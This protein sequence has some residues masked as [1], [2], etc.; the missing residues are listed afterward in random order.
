MTSAVIVSLRIKTTPAR[1]FDV[2]TQ[3][4]DAWWQP[5]GLFDLTPKGDGVLRFEPGE[6][7]RL[8]TT[9]PNGKEFE[10]GR[11]L[12]WAPGERLMFTWRQVTFPPDLLTEVDVRFEPVGKDTRV[13]LEHRG[14]DRV[15]QDH[16]ARHG[17]PL[18]IFQKH[19]ADRHYRLLCS[20]RDHL[21]GRPVLR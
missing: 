7:G 2:F 13:T 19:L 1:A 14:W 12:V 5:N 17:F 11:I 4:I 10:I 18:D 9:L 20:L 6:S 21:T 3:E 15:P 16:A 8:V